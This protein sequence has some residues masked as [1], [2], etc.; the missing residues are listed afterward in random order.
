MSWFGQDG[1]AL[2]ELLDLPR[3][4]AEESVDST[5]DVA[6]ALAAA[7]AS[8]GT[9]VVAEAQRS[10]RGRSGQR[11]RSQARAGIWA[12]LIERPAD[13]AAL[14][15][16]SLRVGLRLA[17]V[18]ERWTSAAI[19]LK[20]PNDLFVGDLK[21]AGILI[22][23]RWRDQRPDWVAIGLGINL[24]PP[25]DPPGAALTGADARTVLAEC[26]PALRA[27][28][29]ARGR[30]GDD[31][32]RAFAARDLARGRQLVA[33]AAGAACGI[34]DDGALLIESGGCV[35]PWRSGSIVFAG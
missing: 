29:F 21:L 4:V 31:E 7:G 33:P 24:L 8:A 11:W 3:V 9:L 32:C 30:L 18:L 19:R 23:A 2:A 25:D 13:A 5:M 26:L 15:V 12:T 17:P 35:T 27:A 16:L 34:A 20:W 28:A 10:G 6:H 14:E 22:E 1:A